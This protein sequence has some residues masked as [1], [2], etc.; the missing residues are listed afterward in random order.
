MTVKMEKIARERQQSRDIVKEIINFGVSEQQKL[1]VIF[2]L[3]LNLENNAAL[4]E[5]ISVVKKY[6][7]SI[8]KEEETEDNIKDSLEK[9]PKLII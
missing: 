6:R 5:I 8:N 4:K 7:E 9:K 2:E 3:A 1:D